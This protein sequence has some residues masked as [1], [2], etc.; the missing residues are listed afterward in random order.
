MSLLTSPE[1]ARAFDLSRETRR[2][3]TAT[4]ATSGAS[5]A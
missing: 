2:C 3:A 1:A 4:A 5:S